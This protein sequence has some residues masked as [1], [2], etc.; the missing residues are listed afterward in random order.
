MQK[1]TLLSLLA[2]ISCASVCAQEHDYRFGKVSLDELR[3][4]SYEKDPD[5]DAVILYEDNYLSYQFT[6]TV[7]L[8]Q[9]SSN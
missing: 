8:V 3:M 5:A 1:L 6:T 7:S 9:S 2:I 4:E